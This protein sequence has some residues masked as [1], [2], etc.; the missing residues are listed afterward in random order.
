MG[1]PA[2]FD[3]FFGFYCFFSKKCRYYLLVFLYE[4]LSFSR[5][6]N[7]V[8]RLPGTQGGH[9]KR[10]G[11]VTCSEIRHDLTDSDFFLVDLKFTPSPRLLVDFL[12]CN[13]LKLFQN[14][15]FWNSFLG[16]N[17]KTGLLAGFSK[18]LSKTNRILKQTQLSLYFR[19]P[20]PGS[21][22]GNAAVGMR[23]VCV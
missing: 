4:G 3:V 17:G 8:L 20:S 14:F 22:G 9:L 11:R 23:G 5:G 10:K 12:F 13:E 21:N 16:F 19:A 2:F 18:S 1:G 7:G 15:S 6:S